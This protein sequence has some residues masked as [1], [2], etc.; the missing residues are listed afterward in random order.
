MWKLR[1]HF[2]PALR[3]TRDIEDEFYQIAHEALN[4][5]LKHADAQRVE[6]CVQRA[7]SATDSAQLEE[8]ER[9]QK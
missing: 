3:L 9:P 2:D 4:N 6:I 5:A 1:F 8:S 7:E